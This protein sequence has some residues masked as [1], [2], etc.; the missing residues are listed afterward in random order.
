M[1]CDKYFV[2]SFGVKVCARNHMNVMINVTTRMKTDNQ[3][4][5]YINHFRIIIPFE[6][7]HLLPTYTRDKENCFCRFSRETRAIINCIYYQLITG[8]QRWTHIY[9][10]MIRRKQR[11]SRLLRTLSLLFTCYIERAS[12]INRN[13]QHRH[14]LAVN[15]YR[16]KEGDRWLG[17]GRSL[18]RSGIGKWDAIIKR[19]LISD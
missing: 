14:R 6:L 9:I 12:H 10:A 1:F 15:E 16:N 13:H 8:I 4:S 2:K 19:Y 5:K 7:S 17:C 3:M 11:I 18:R